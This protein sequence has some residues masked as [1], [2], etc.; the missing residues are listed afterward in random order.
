MSDPKYQVAL[1]LAA[2][3][4]AVLAA[5][6]Q[7]IATTRRGDLPAHLQRGVR[8]MRGKV[9]GQRFTVGLEHTGDGG[10]ETDLVGMVV[11]A[12]GGRSDVRASV[13]DS[14]GAPTH[15]LVLLGIAGGLALAGLG[16]LA[17]VATGFAALVAIIAT[18]RDATGLID[19]DEAAFLV[20][21]LRG[22]LDPLAAPHPHP[23]APT[24]ADPVTPAS[25]S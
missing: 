19:H 12:E 2:P 22:V 17:W 21:W 13:L 7:A 15:A 1:R 16:E 8:G 6:H 9:R 11:P 10:E 5:I 18:F 23:P 3:P 20:Q 4:D 14:H 25:A 24:D